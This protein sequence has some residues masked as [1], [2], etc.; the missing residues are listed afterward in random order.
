MHK[1]NNYAFIDSQ[2]LNL[3]IRS[4]GWELDFRKF[5][6]YLKN[7]YSVQRA[8]LFIGQMAGME[9]LYDRLQEMGY[10]L[11]FK[12]TTEY[13]VDGKTMVKGNVD[14][15]LVLYASAKVFNQYDKAIIV[16]GDGDFHCLVEYLAEKNKLGHVLVPNRKFSKLL[17][18]FDTYIKR[19]DHARASLQLKKTKKDQD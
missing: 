13:K 4:Q 2:N 6:L 3:G 16:S 12:P 8:Y 19:L 18:R 10:H 7:K 14:A 17:H 11:I 5:R 1:Q 9:A 15:E